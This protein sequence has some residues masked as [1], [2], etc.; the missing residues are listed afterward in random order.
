MSVQASQSITREFTTHDTTGANANAAS[1]PTGL[2]R[3]NGASNAATVTISLLSGKTGEYTASFT[4]PSG[5]AT[6]DQL[7]LV[8]SATVSSIAVSAVVWSDTVD[9]TVA[10]RSTVDAAGVWGYATRILTAGTNIVLAKGTGITGFNDLDAAGIRAAIGLASANLDTQLTGLTAT[11]A[12]A[13]AAAILVNPTNKIAT[14]GSNRVSVDKTDYALSTAGVDAIA[15]AV[16]A[17]LMDEGDGQAVLTAIV[18]KINSVDADL[19]G[20]S[21]TAIASAVQTA[22][23][24]VG[25]KLALVQAQAD[26]IGTNSGD[27]SNA[28]TAQTN[29]ATAATQSTAAATSAAAVVAKLPA[30]GAAI[31]DATAAAQTTLQATATAINN[32][33]INLPASPAGVGDVPTAAQNAAATWGAGTRTLTSGAA[34]SVDEIDAKLTANHGAGAW[35]SAG[36]FAGVRA[37]TITVNLDAEDPPTPA[38]SARVRITQGNV[39][40]GRTAS[41]SGVVGYSLDDGDYILSIRK[42]GY[43][44]SPTTL[45]VDAAHTSFVITLTPLA[46]TPAISPDQ[47]RC[48]LSCYDAQGNPDPEAIITLQQTAA[49]T[50]GAWPS[51]LLELAC[52]DDGDVLDPVDGAKGVLLARGV[53]YRGHRGTGVVD[54]ETK[55]V[56][57]TPDADVFDLPAMIGQDV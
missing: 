45:L 15:A 22:I 8:I 53:A 55:W 40:D 54:R 34:P 28:Q 2:L 4:V 41:S 35:G 57:F 11:I 39:T 38:A 47:A 25:G 31:G 46:R 23:E 13:V 17:A 16:E 1:T 5:A 42:D 20:L 32:K 43:T 27:S 24:R 50:A 44:C 30:G 26:K 56:P 37:V 10:S 49:G 18:N 29:A 19:S 33:T 3:V 36:I 51:N 48:Y 52:D 21:I 7:D 9:A 12:T 6:G 14:D